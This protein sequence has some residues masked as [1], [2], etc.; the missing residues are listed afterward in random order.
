MIKLLI[1]ED[2]IQLNNALKMYFEKAEYT[3]SQAF[4]CIEAEDIIKRKNID[5]IVADI[6]LPDQSG[7]TFAEKIRQE[8][9]IPIIFLTAK[10]EEQ[11]ILDGYDAGCEE[12]VTK[13]ISPKILQK[14]MEA[15][16]SRQGDK[17]NILFY[18]KLKI[19]YEKRRVWKNETE[20]KLSNKEWKILN[21][22][23]RN[24]GKIMTKEVLL[25]SV[26]DID[27]DFVDEH[28]VTVVINRLRKKIEE[29]TR[30]PVYIKNVFG[31]GYTFGE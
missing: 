1:L 7:L 16:L 14:K 26:W 29:N 11:D 19:H 30:E 3:I 12:Y 10:D 25:E 4:S 9:K 15:I 5:I 27:G 6:S 2:D 22:L 20:I 13:P 31:V 18:K 28:V 17:E 24:K 21:L 8:R 23:A